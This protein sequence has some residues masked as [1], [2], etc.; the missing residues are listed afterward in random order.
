M[1]EIILPATQDIRQRA[2]ISGA[3]DDMQLMA[4]WVASQNSKATQRLYER[5]G[6]M[7][8]EF[9]RSRGGL[10]AASLRD[11][12]DFEAMLALRYLPNS[13]LTIANSARSLFMFAQRCDYI[14]KSPA[15]VIKAPR[16][17]G[18]KSSK[19]LTEE[20]ALAII[21]APYKRRDRVLLELLYVT[22]IRAEEAATL[23][24]KDVRPVGNHVVIQVI[25]KGAKVR[26]LKL[27]VNASR[28]LL[29]L[30][31]LD[32]VPEDAVFSAVGK[33]HPHPWTH[34]SP[35]SFGAIVTK[36]RADAGVTKPVS[37]H[38]F[39]HAYAQHARKRG[40]TKDDIQ[41]ALGHASQ[42]TTEGYLAAHEGLM[43]SADFITERD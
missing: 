19:D 34:M 16:R 24:W 29:E 28:R 40:Q 10:G 22:G 35:L 13:A 38:W 25:G 43:L 27:P 6:N 37:P 1:N 8:L 31:S 3:T 9:L 39:R 36:A 26:S 17:E 41:D 11:W 20:E 12:K 23:H 15:H 14:Y 2:D 5:A 33:P 32:N 7:L 30:R 18:R 21:R 42:S 4:M